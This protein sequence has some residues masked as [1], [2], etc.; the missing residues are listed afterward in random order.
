MNINEIKRREDLPV[1][2]N[3]NG[4]TNIGAEIGVRKGV[5][6]AQILKQWHGKLLYS[7]DCW[8]P[9]KNGKPNK[10]F[11]T[12]IAALSKFK[13]RSAIIKDYSINAA[14]KIKNKSLDFCYI[15]ANHKYEHVKNDLELW[16]PKVK[17]G[18]VFCGHDF[19]IDEDEWLARRKK[20]GLSQKKWP[21]W[22]V[23]KA[24]NEFCVIKNITIHVDIPRSAEPTSWYTIKNV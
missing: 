5:Y 14:K 19:S 24:V 2:L 12:A 23:Q 4:L 1:F 18:G 8:D 6:S 7:I 11:P 16:W 9:H 3:E 10:H 13:T 22:S 15:D 17:K 21:N 20:K